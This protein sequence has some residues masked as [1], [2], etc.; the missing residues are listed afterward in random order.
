MSL[1]PSTWTSTLQL[2]GLN[3]IMTSKRLISLTLR[4][5]WNIF[6]RVFYCL[7]LTQTYLYPT[8]KTSS[9]RPSMSLYLRRKLEINSHSSPPPI[10]PSPP[11]PQKNSESQQSF[12]IAWEHPTFR[13]ATSG[14][15]AKWRLR[16]ERRNS[17]LMTCL[18]PDLGSASD[19]S[20]CERNLTLN[21]QMERQLIKRPTSW[22]TT[23]VI[24]VV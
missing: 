4:K 15:P 11:P 17:I 16:N 12:L 14:L 7:M 20:C 23:S 3:I 5:L 18:Y 22:A 8:R 10:P 24:W 19:W 21:Q 9:G 6:P 13:D 1:L 2:L